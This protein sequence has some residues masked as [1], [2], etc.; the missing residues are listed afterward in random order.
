[1]DLMSTAQL[2]GNFGEFVGAIAVVATLFYL[3]VQVRHSKDATEANTLANKALSNAQSQESMVA[4]NE[5]VAADPELAMLMSRV[6]EGAKLDDFSDVERFRV[7]LVLRSIAQ[8]FESIYFRHQAGMLE[9]HVWLTRRTWLSG[10]LA[11]PNLSELWLNE[12]RSSLYTEEFI[13]EIQKPANIRI[14]SAGL[15]VDSST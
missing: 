8:R 5:L 12:R 11:N 15:R 4:T 10:L 6:T 13:D 14:G 2:L 3:A 7:I 9:E 1:M